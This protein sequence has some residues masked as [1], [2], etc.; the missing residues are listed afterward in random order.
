[1]SLIGFVIACAS[2]GA[3]GTSPLV[4]YPN[5]TLKAY[6]GLSVAGAGE[7]VMRDGTTAPTAAPNRK[8]TLSAAVGYAP[9]RWATVAVSVPYITNRG[10]DG[11]SRA[12]VGD[13][14]IETRL[15]AVQAAWDRPMV[16]Q[17]QGLATYKQARARSIYETEDPFR[18][19]DVFGNGYDELSAGAD[20]WWG[21][22]P[23][24]P[25]FAYLVTQALPRTQDGQTLTR[26]LRQTVTLSVG[27]TP[28]A[29]LHAAIGVIRDTKAAEAI[30]GEAVPKSD[31][32]QH[33]GFASLRY[34]PTPADEIRLSY[35]RT[36]FAFKN[37]ETTRGTIMTLGY[38]R[39]L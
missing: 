29:N 5:E 38:A 4:L 13:P 24:M 23:V 20:L 14:L 3:G 12:A 10:D 27:T 1:M 16:P 22:A 25:G 17:V 35:L 28:I 19:L 33:N 21:M 31:A 7:R 18:L 36:A 6:V 30:D 8:E 15:T 11:D 9:T 2:C 39:H 26:G 34:N 37:A 32:K